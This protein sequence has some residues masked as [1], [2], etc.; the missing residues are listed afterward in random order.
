MQGV[1]RSKSPTHHAVTALKRYSLQLQNVIN[2]AKQSSFIG[3][4]LAKIKDAFIIHV[5]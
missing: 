4:S 5:N 3:L 2:Q 1:V